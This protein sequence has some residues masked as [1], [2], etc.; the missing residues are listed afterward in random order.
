[1]EEWAASPPTKKIT[2]L[3]QYHGLIVRVWIDYFYNLRRYYDKVQGTVAASPPFGST[4][5]DLQPTQSCHF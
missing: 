2:E 5:I 3:F 1:L 4:Q